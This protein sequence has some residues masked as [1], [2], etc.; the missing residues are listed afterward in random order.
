MQIRIN[1]QLLLLMLAEKLVN[2]GC[3]LIQIN[4]DG[5]FYVGKIENR[6]QINAACKEWETLTKLTLESEDYERMYQY[7]I[8]DYIAIGKGYSE[9]HN[10]NLIKTKGMFLTEV[11][12]GKGMPP[13]IIPEAIVKYFADN[14]PV[15][16]TV[17]ECKDINKF[18][19]Y[20]K[21]GK[22]FSVEYGDQLIQRINRFYMSTT[23]SQYLYKCKVDKNGKRSNYEK[24]NAQSGVTI[25]N[26]LD[27]LTDFPSNVNYQ[28]YINQANSIVTEMRVKQLTLF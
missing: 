11:S 3:R 17:R 2:L 9:S 23:G 22:E 15:I 16:Q 20:Q 8:N 10:P 24:I 25:V 18:I 7:A 26:R 5:I 1:G 12:L 28:Y 6:D 14:I 13:V 27:L 4:T 19:T 21:V